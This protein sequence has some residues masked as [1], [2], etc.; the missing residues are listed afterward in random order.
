MASVH[1]PLEAM[2]PV[3]QKFGE[4]SQKKMYQVQGAPHWSTT[5][6]IA[7]DTFNRLKSHAKSGGFIQKE[8]K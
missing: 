7:V 4:V 2:P 3:I 8:K 5:P 6:Q 1:K